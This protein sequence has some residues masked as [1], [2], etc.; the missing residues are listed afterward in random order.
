MTILV[1]VSCWHCVTLLN[2]E[3][4]TASFY[5]GFKTATRPSVPRPRSRTYGLRLLPWERRGLGRKLSRNEET[6]TICSNSCSDCRSACISPSWW[7]SGR[8]VLQQ[9]ARWR[10]SHSTSGLRRLENFNIKSTL[11]YVSRQWRPCTN[12]MML[13]GWRVGQWRFYV[14]AR[15][16][17]PPP[18]NLA[19]VPPNFWTQ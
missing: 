2:V 6:R 1:S 7:R 11:P 13:R 18:P 4:S 12:Y 16:H 15:G 17:S 5:F 10:A 19:Q 9:W 8:Q 3:K 14:G